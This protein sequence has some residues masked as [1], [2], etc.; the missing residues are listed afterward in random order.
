MFEE[1][2]N[3]DKYIHELDLITFLMG[4]NASQGSVN[5]LGLLNS[6]EPIKTIPQ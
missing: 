4:Q 3:L 2:I 1:K 6:N 5:L